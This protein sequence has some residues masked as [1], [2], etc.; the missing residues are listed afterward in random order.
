[1]RRFK[2][3]IKEIVERSTLPDYRLFLDESAK[4]NK[5]VVMTRDNAK[6]V[7]EANKAGKLSWVSYFLQKKLS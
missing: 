3:E 1:M 2:Q 5:L 6:L 4:P 7:C